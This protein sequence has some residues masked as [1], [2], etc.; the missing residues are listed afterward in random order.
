M[1]LSV[2]RDQNHKK[3]RFNNKKIS[4]PLQQPHSTKIKL[5]SLTL[6]IQ[7]EKKLRFIHFTVDSW[8]TTFVFFNV[9]YFC[10]CTF[11]IGISKN[12]KA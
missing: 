4:S 9:A 5:P 8:N 12:F 11:S 3:I 7:P 1:G 10:V 2:M 6:N